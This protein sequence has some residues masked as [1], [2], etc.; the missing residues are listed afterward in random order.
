MKSD[1]TA[2]LMFVGVIVL[3][4]L[5]IWRSV[6]SGRWRYRGGVVRRESRP[7]IFWGIIAFAGATVVFA[8]LALLAMLDADIACAGRG[9]PADCYRTQ[10]Q[11]LRAWAH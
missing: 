5:V 6:K 2:F 4:S 7:R 10:I 8:M 1:V 3:E 9:I 11:A